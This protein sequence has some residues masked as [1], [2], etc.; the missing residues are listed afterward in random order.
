MLSNWL[1]NPLGNDIGQNGYRDVG[2]D[3]SKIIG[4]IKKILWMLGIIE[5]VTKEARV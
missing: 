2:I 4:N 3:E 1:K 5:R